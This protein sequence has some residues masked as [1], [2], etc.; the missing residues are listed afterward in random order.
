VQ[1]KN[2]K[3]MVRMGGGSTTLEKFVEET[4]GK[5]SLSGGYAAALIAA[6]PHQDGDEVKAP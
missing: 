3:M 1:V 4:K 2:D 6:S 5:T